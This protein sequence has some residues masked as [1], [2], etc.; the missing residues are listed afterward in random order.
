M[1]ED[2][3]KYISVAKLAEILEINYDIL[4]HYFTI[5]DAPTRKRMQ[6]DDGIRSVMD[7][8]S[9][10]QYMRYFLP[11]RLTASVEFAIR[12]QAKTY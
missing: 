1:E 4:R 5:A 10:I 7:S 11:R 3:K 9:L 6:T 12:T 8:E 2:E